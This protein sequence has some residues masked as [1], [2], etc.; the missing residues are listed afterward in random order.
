MGV[1][2]VQQATEEQYHAHRTAITLYLSRKLAHSS[3]QQKDQQEKR[4]QRQLEKQ[5]MAAGAPLIFTESS[6]SAMVKQPSAK[7][8]YG[9]SRPI[10]A[11]TN[12]FE[13]AGDYD[14]PIESLLTADQIQQF[15]SESSQMLQEA[16]A[17]MASIEKAQSS[18]LEISALQN[19]LVVQLTQQT[20]LTD[21]LWEDAV[22][23]TGRVQEGNKQLKQA[24]ERNREGRI[25]LLIFLMGASLSLL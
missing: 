5:S 2:S 17:Q 21:K 22:F 14:E 11:A 18:L 12:G 25:W 4:I 10:M 7:P 19:E 23:V 13:D 9:D 15:E 24:R 16:N 3:K 1:N 20:E 8:I 6:A